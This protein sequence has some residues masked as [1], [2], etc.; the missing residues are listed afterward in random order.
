MEDG[1]LVL[2]GAWKLDLLKDVC[3]LVDWALDKR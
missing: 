2:A 1:V 3:L